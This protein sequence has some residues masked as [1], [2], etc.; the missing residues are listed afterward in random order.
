MVRLDTEVDTVDIATIDME[1][2]SVM[3]KDQER[4][5]MKLQHH[6][7][8]L[9]LKNDYEA[10]IAELTRSQARHRQTYEAENSA[11]KEKY[12]AKDVA[13]PSNIAMLKQS[14]NGEI[15][16]ENYEARIATLTHQN[17]QLKQSHANEILAMKKQCDDRIALANQEI[18]LIKT[19]NT[20]AIQTLKEEYEKIIFE[21]K[22][23][24]WVLSLLSYFFLH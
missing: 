12:L 14:H 1:E 23:K 3:M 11:L 7:E 19:T 20:F 21:N 9:K 5:A 16:R 4:E 2:F 8:I 13:G 17:D 15:Q 6:E 24:A 22:K 18:D 10:K